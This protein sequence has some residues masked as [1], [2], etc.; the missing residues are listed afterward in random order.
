[1]F[2]SKKCRQGEIF[3]KQSLLHHLILHLCD[4]LNFFTI[5]RTSTTGNGISI[6]WNCNGFCTNSLELFFTTTGTSVY[7][8]SLLKSRW[9]K[10]WWKTNRP[11]QI[12]NPF[13]RDIFI[14]L[15]I[16]RTNFNGSLQH[17]CFIFHVVARV[18]RILHSTK[19]RNL[20]SIN[21]LPRF[22]KFVLGSRWRCLLK[23]LFILKI[24]RF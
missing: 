5:K 14:N 20:H 3:L 23:H 19:F 17:A 8:S 2:K 9:H 1:M 4:Y 18:T 7:F 16:T 22:S 21:I 12:D 13:S 15:C 11:C 24:L 10:I 6:K